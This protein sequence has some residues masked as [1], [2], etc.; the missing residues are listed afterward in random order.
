MVVLNGQSALKQDFV[1][2]V[3]IGI[4]SIFVIVYPYNVTYK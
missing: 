3:S 1:F 4:C 2:F